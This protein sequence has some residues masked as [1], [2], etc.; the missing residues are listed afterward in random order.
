MLA[1][2]ER[3]LDS[4][5]AEFDLGDLVE[6]VVVERAD[7]ARTAGVTLACRRDAGPRG[8]VVVGEPVLTRQLLCNLVDNAVEYNVGGGTVDVVV[9]SRVVRVENSGPSIDPA[10]VDDLTRPFCRGGVQTRSERQ[11]DGRGG[12][13]RRHS[14]LGLSIV[15]A[16]A[17]AHGWSLGLRPRPAGGL[18][19]TLDTRRPAA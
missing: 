19:V 17:D 9:G 15:A 4:R 13:A 7:A 5:T 14:G 16:V 8:P 2:A 10:V 3:G 6:E 18:V 1:E 12:A 11:T